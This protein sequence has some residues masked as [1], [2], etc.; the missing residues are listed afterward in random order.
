MNNCVA[1]FNFGN[2]CILELLV[3]TYTLRKHYSGRIVWMLAKNDEWNQQLAQQVGNLNVDIVWSDFNKIKRNTK[4]AIKPL[5]FK[6]LFDMGI[7][8]VIM[9]DG[10]LLFLDSID[11]LWLPLEKSGTLLT[12]FCD[13]KTNG[14]IMGARLGQMKNIV[15]DKTLKKIMSGYPAVNIG[16]MGFTKEKG[17]NALQRWADVTE[18]LAGKHIADEIA[19]HVLVTNPSTYI[20]A[21]T[22][23]ASAKIGDLNKIETNKVVHYHG[24]SQ[25][26]G[27][28]DVRYE[29]RRRSSRLWMAYLYNFYQSGLVPESSM[30]E[31]YATGGIYEILQANP[32]LPFECSQE[33]KI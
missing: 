13:W 14:K 18:K 6:Q 2:K 25:G 29:N 5:L 31:Q 10:D 15:D 16:V 27:E 30:W 24:S 8:S 4:S 26:G 19:A 1:F 9:C 21:A 3:A 7:N 33:F 23:N 11:D 32:N 22:F 20:A 28:V 17:L 12:Q